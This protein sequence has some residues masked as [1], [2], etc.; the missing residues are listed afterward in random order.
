MDTHTT[1]IFSIFRW[2]S[3][4][5]E[6]L[7][8]LKATKNT[9]S[10]GFVQKIEKNKRAGKPLLSKK[11]KNKPRHLDGVVSFK[12]YA[13]V[14]LEKA[15]QIPRLFLERASLFDKQSAQLCLCD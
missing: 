14:Y 2:P 3:G 1:S 4:W 7:L 9:K 13:Q 8:Y 10:E 12:I 11:S 5:R 15:F 6:A